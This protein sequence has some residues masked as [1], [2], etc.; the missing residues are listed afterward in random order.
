MPRLP[1]SDEQHERQRSHRRIRG[2]TA[3]INPV[4]RSAHKCPPRWTSSRRSA[5]MPAT[6]GGRR[7][8]PRDPGSLEERSTTARRSTASTLALSPGEILGLLGPNGAGKTTLVRSVAGRVAPDRRLGRDPRLSTLPGRPRPCGPGLGPAGD[9]ALSPALAAREP[10]DVRPL[11]GPRRARPSTPGIR[12]SLD[13][14][15]LADRADDKTDKLSGGMK[16]RLNIAAGT[17][18]EPAGAPAR[19]AHGR[20]G[21]PVARADLRDDRRAQGAAASRSSTRPTTWRRP[22]GSA[23]ASRS[24]TTAGSSRSAR[25]EELVRRTRRRAAGRSR[26]RPSRRSPLRSRAKLATARGAAV[27]G[28]R[29]QALGRGPRGRD[30][31]LLELFHAERRSRCAT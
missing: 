15:G 17:I 23:T 5:R 31:Q 9:R 20:R 22:S 12:T 10:L 8:S 11:P 14:I 30:P 6:D 7:A 1:A 2:R 21:S 4:P 24:S 25:K 18:H 19:R 16:R 27:D 3:Q 29:V 28:S 26:S 13:W